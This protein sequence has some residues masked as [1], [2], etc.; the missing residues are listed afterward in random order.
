MAKT[1][2][3]GSRLPEPPPPARSKGAGTQMSGAGVRESGID[4][5]AGVTPTMMSGRPSSDTVRPST[6]ARPPYVRCHSAWLIIAT[7]A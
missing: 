6:S 7:A 4:R 5:P 1:A 3:P 2:G